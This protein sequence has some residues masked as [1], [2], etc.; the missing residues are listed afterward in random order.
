VSEYPY[1]AFTSQR[2]APISVGDVLNKLWRTLRGNW[3]LYLG[4]GTPLAAMGILFVTLYIAALFASGVFPPH[5]GAQPDLTHVLPVLQWIFPTI[6]VGTILNLIVFALYQAATAFAALKEATGEKT[7]VG[8]AYTAAWRKA[9]RY[10]WLAIL[11]YLCVAGPILVAAALIS[12]LAIAAQTGGQPNPAAIFLIFLL[13][14][15]FFVGA[16]VYAIWMMLSLGMAFPASVAEDLS[17]AA[18][19]KRSARLSCKVKGKLFLSHLIVYA[20]SY[21][22][23]FVLE[24]GCGIIFAIGALLSSA[25]HLSIAANIA[26]GSVLGLAFLVLLFAYMSLIWAAYVINFTIVYCD[27]RLR[28]DG[29]ETEPATTAGGIVPA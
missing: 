19:L 17:A 28:L 23:I 8:E 1:A 12:G 22:A 24:I 25:L 13:V 2:P 5:P 3:K 18:A 14:F 16:M 15:L 29:P 21:A 20:I 7:T 4:L 9:A 6:F 11:Q 26:A 27:Q 10:C